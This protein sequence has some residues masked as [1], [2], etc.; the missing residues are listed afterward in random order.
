MGTSGK[1]HGSNGY[2]SPGWVRIAGAAALI[3]TVL[4]AIVMVTGLGGTHGPGRHLPQAAAEEP[5]PR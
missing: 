3:V 1:R 2:A 5:S 4:I